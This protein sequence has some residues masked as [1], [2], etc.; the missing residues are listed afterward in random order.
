MPYCCLGL[1]PKDANNSTRHRACEQSYGGPKFSFVHSYKGK[2]LGGRVCLLGGHPPL[3]VAQG[4]LQERQPS[5]TGPFTIHRHM[6]AWVVISHK[7]CI[8]PAMPTGYRHSACK[9]VA[10]KPCKGAETSLAGFGHPVWKLVFRSLRAASLVEKLA[11]KV[12]SSSK[13]VAHGHFSAIIIS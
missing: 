13:I 11:A 10:P 9:P 1:G 5:R 8:R 2:V 4:C 7:P 6:R 12:T 3:Y